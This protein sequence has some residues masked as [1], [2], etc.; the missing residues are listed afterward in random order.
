MRL[1]IGGCLIAGWMVLPTF[2][3]D[4]NL[5]I[6][7]DFL[8]NQIVL[9]GV[10]NGHGPYNLILD[11]GTLAS[12]IDLQVARELGLPLGAEATSE[13]VGAG[14]S[15]GRHTTFVD[16]QIGG[17]A[18]HRLDAAVFDLSGI[19]RGLGRPLHGV[20]GF[21]FLDSRI[22]QID[23]F[24]RRIRFYEASPFPLN[25]HRDDEKSISFP[26]QFQNGKTISYNDF[27]TSIG[28]IFFFPMMYLSL[29]RPIHKAS[30]Q[31]RGFHRG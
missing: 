25:V 3:A 16:L 12:T 29:F 2:A 17:I 10:L 28:I 30:H 18:V 23:Y 1:G 19:S 11:T 15:T 20:L 5:E 31:Q 27:V 13:G 21:G 14:H 8:H 9:R 7:F 6:P 24:Q 22:T 4:S 26:M